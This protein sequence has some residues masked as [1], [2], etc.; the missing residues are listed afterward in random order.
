MATASIAAQLKDIRA[1]QD[2]H[3]E[4][5]NGNGKPGA[6]TRLALLE[7]HLGILEKKLDTIISLVAGLFIMVLG[8]GIVWFLFTELP[9]LHAALLMMAK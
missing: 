5:I 9:A 3:D 1:C 8:G 2:E 7:D 6:K 4:F